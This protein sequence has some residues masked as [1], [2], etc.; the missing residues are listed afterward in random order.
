MPLSGY[1]FGL[2]GANSNLIEQG[3]IIDVVV[4]DLMIDVEVELQ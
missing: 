3:L 4:D 1:T 2:G